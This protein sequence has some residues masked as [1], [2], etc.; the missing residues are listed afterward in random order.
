MHS[1]KFDF[2]RSALF[3]H[4]F[5][6]M[7]EAHLV[8]PTFWKHWPRR[9]NSNGPS[10]FC[11]S[12]SRVKIFDLKLGSVY[13]RK[14][15]VPNWAWSGAT[16]PVISLEFESL[17]FFSKEILIWLGCFRFRPS[18]ISLYGVPLA[19]KDVQRAYQLNWG[20]YFVSWWDLTLSQS[21]LVLTCDTH[22][23]WSRF[24]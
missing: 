17:E 23:S 9:L 20:A 21:W 6:M 2:I 16:W 4:C 12:I 24:Y 11:V 1:S 14:Y 5:G 18:L 22:G 19:P 8:R 15:S 13:A 7:L 10:S 3:G